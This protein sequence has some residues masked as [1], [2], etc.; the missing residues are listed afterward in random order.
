MG[1]LLHQL[2]IGEKKTITSLLLFLL[3][4]SLEE[5]ENV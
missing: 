2:F 1:V 3:L 4:Y 5:T